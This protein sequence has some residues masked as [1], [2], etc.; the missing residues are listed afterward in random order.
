MSSKFNQIYEKSIKNPDGLEACMG[1][2]RDS[3]KKKKYV[4]KQKS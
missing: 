4:L 2:E 1:K 3:K